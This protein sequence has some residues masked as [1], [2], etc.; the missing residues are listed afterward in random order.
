MPEDE[1]KAFTEG[2]VV[3]VLIDKDHKHR[4]VLVVNCGKVWDPDIVSSDQLFRLF[5]LSKFTCISSNCVSKL[6]FPLIF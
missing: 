4:R 3:N 1:E 5:Y 2:G 6:N